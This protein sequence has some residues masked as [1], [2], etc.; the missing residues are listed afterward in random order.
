MINKNF[1]QAT[2]IATVVQAGWAK[3]NNFYV[4]C[5]INNPAATSDDDQHLNAFV[6]LHTDDERAAFYQETRN[7][8]PE[9]AE[10][11]AYIVGA[12]QRKTIDVAG[13]FNQKIEDAK[14]HGHFSDRT[15][16]DILEN[17]LGGMMVALHGVVLTDKLKDGT[18]PSDN[19]D[20]TKTVFLATADK[21]VVTGLLK[22]HAY[23]ED[24]LASDAAH[25]YAE[26]SNTMARFVLTPPENGKPA[27]VAAYAVTDAENINFNQLS[28]NP[29]KMNR[30]IDHNNRPFHE[31]SD[32]FQ[33]QGFLEMN[34][35]YDSK[36]HRFS[37]DSSTLDSGEHQ[38]LDEESLQE[39]AADWHGEHSYQVSRFRAMQDPDTLD[40][41]S[42][43]QLAKLD[44]MR[45]VL[46]AADEPN[47]FKQLL[48][49]IN[50][51]D[52]TA[53]QGITK[54]DFANDKDLS[55]EQQVVFDIAKSMAKDPSKV[56]INT[57][58]H[59]KLNISPKLEEAMTDYMAASY[60]RANQTA[61]GGKNTLFGKSSSAQSNAKN[62]SLDVVHTTNYGDVITTVIPIVKVSEV[63]P[64]GQY[65]AV[66]DQLHAVFKTVPNVNWTISDGGKS[67]YKDNNVSYHDDKFVPTKLVKNANRDINFGYAPK[68]NLLE[69]DKP[70]NEGK[71]LKNNVFTNSFEPYSDNDVG[72]VDLNRDFAPNKIKLESVDQISWAIPKIA[73][74]KNFVALMEQ[75]QADPSQAIKRYDEMTSVVNQVMG[76]FSKTNLSI[77]AYKAALSIDPASRTE[78]HQKV[79]DL[80]LSD[81]LVAVDIA[82]AKT[83]ETT[84]KHYNFSDVM[85][86]TLNADKPI[87][88]AIT[89]DIADKLADLNNDGMDKFKAARVGETIEQKITSLKE[90]T[91]TLDDFASQVRDFSNN[92]MPTPSQSLRV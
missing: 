36:F 16:K 73:F 38:Y 68:L 69:G 4:Q 64:K 12:R 60:V 20:T 49:N 77:H 23:L 15:N 54:T 25:Q 81:H 41:P 7:L 67:R 40:E 63:H 6:R 19:S 76:G 74:K 58:T 87:R 91:M 78:A 32:S 57:A 89:D 26:A 47:R 53:F 34:V 52:P 90:S 33:R 75:R 48:T 5:Q 18:A 30:M 9:Q 61:E 29:S 13:Q 22:D 62:A 24:T 55:S 31:K 59:D 71:P 1:L 86:V 51:G 80:L 70:A 43:A 27:S 37:F 46:L 2:T 82:D 79:R 65:T 88:R 84:T 8:S 44:F 28:A 3:D 50:N 39:V 56:F 10:R 72:R 42:K 85:A 11:D 66:S 92:P 45:I 17:H 21:I 35:S 83:G 14:S